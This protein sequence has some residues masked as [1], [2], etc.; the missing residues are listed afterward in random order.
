MA[1]PSATAAPEYMSALLALDDQRGHQCQR[2]QLGER[3]DRQDDPSAPI[4]VL[5]NERKGDNGEAYRERFENEISKWEEDRNH[6]QVFVGNVGTPHRPQRCKGQQ[7]EQQTC[8]R[9]PQARCLDGAPL[10]EFNLG[11]CD[12][13]VLHGKILIMCPL[14]VSYLVI[15]RRVDSE[16]VTADCKE[17]DNHHSQGNEC[18]YER[19]TH[20]AMLLKS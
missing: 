2:P 4:P 15:T 16:G 18:D 1:V 14:M 7:V 10:E 11:E 13:R 8:D 5:V 17:D 12:G 19:R 20:K 3:G 9:Q 6:Q